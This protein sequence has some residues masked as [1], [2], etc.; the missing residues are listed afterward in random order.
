MKWV[1]VE[2]H[3]GRFAGHVGRGGGL[4]TP[5][6]LPKYESKQESVDQVH[7]TGEIFVGVWVGLK[8]RV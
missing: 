4:P 7:W 5:Q 1:K 2:V 3:I 6:G 8:Q